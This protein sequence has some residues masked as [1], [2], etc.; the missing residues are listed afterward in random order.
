MKETQSHWL[1]KQQLGKEEL[2]TG[3]VRR[4]I[5]AKRARR[6]LQSAHTRAQRDRLCIHPIPQI[7][8]VPSPSTDNER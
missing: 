8:A 5:I 4:D 3:A 6:Q 7:I 1:L 2:Y